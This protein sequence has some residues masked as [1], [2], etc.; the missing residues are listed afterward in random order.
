MKNKAKKRKNQLRNQINLLKRKNQKKIT[1]SQVRN[2]IRAIN[3]R[4]NRM[5]PRV[6]QNRR[7]HK[8]N[9][10]RNLFQKRRVIKISEIQK[11]QLRSKKA[12]L[13]RKLQKSRKRAM[14]TVILNPIL[15]TKRRNLAAKLLSKVKN[16]IHHQKDLQ[17][18]HVARKIMRKRKMNHRN[19]RNPPSQLKSDKRKIGK[20]HQNPLSLFKSEKRR[21]LRKQNQR[22]L[23]RKRKNQ[24]QKIILTINNRN[25]IN[26]IQHQKKL[27]KQILSLKNLIKKRRAKFLRKMMTLHKNPRSP[28]NHKK[29][30]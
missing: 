22:K 15:K 23:K 20:A 10:A 30:L 17:E 27:K 25:Q 5:R 29:R 28:K 21:S 24:C 16:R 19:L 11:L 7:C 3:L 2:L 8:R 12:R 4:I 18:L 9:L 13:Q 14:M 26:L 1:K 6:H